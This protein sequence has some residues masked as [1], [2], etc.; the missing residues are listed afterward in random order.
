MLETWPPV[1]PDPLFKPATADDTMYDQKKNIHDDFIRDSC[2]NIRVFL[3]QGNDDSV[4][5]GSPL[6]SDDVTRRQ[7]TAGETI[8]HSLS[9]YVHVPLSH[10][11]FGTFGPGAVLSE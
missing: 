6:A 9:V 10:R 11:T 5:F 4:H 7:L 3:D 8:I 1:A 2:R